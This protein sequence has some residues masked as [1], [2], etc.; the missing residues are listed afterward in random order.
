[1]AFRNALNRDWMISGYSSR[2]A[3]RVSQ[4]R[5]SP[6]RSRFDR[7]RTRAPWHEQV[8]SRASPARRRREP[9]TTGQK[10]ATESSSLGR[11]RHTG[12]PRGDTPWGFSERTLERGTP[13]CPGQKG[14]RRGFVPGV[15]LLILDV[16]HPVCPD[17]GV[18]IYPLYHSY[19]MNDMKQYAQCRPPHPHRRPGANEAPPPL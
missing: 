8:A 3:A 9:P 7:G 2:G 16:V 5:A 11:D 6:A 18:L 19:H 13:V 4:D 15:P 14:N 10:G 17:Q 1:M 12:T